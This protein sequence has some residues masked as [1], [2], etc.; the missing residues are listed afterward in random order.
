MEPTTWGTKCVDF[1]V[2]E[3]MNTYG[4]RFVGHSRAL[5]CTGSTS[6]MV[7]RWRPR[8][9]GTRPGQPGPRRT[10]MFGLL[11]SALDGSEELQMIE[12]VSLPLVLT[13]YTT[14]KGLRERVA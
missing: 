9:A 7:L 1:I 6:N 2:D 13:W 14:K 11:S 12:G 3:S 5:L 10:R 8:D 4:T